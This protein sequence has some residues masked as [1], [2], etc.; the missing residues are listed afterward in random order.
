MSV[1]IRLQ[2]F[3][4]KGRPIY[5]IVVA[6]ARAPRDGR[7]IA[8]LGS[9][10]PNTNPATID[11]SVDDSV[12]WIRNGAQPTDT[13]R[14]I[15]SYKG[16]MMK[17]HLQDGVA[18]G[19]FS[20]EE[21]ESRFGLWLQSKEERIDAKKSGLKAAGDERR[22]A[23][24]AAESKLNQ[25]RA[26]ALI[27]KKSALAAELEAAAR[28]AAAEA[29]GEDAEGSVVEQDV[30]TPVMDVHE[31]A[32]VAEESITESEPE[33]VAAESTTESEPEA[34]A[35][36][37]TTESEPVAVAAESTTE[38]EPVSSESTPDQS[39]EQATGEA[40]EEADPA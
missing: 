31:P 21:A 8:R 27:A 18:K 36:E 16:V 10:N 37:S 24:M 3:G 4:R 14:A 7:Y 5:H 28:A 26:A 12:Q 19:A 9:Y 22:K 15:L 13:C 1:K 39:A 40:T 32:A 17:K 30:E 29:A 33:A 23:R 2:R 25:E 35:A 11:L 20:A 6:D 38:S 34:V